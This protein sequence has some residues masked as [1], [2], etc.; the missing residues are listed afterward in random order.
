MNLEVVICNE[1]YYECGT[2][3]NTLKLLKTHNDYVD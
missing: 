2:I 3:P 1:D